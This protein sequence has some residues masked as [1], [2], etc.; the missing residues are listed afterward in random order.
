[1]TSSFYS[2]KFVVR[3]SKCLRLPVVRFCVGEGLSWFGVPCCCGVFKGFER[4]ACHV[5]IFTDGRFTRLP[6]KGRVWNWIYFVPQE[7]YAPDPL[8]LYVAI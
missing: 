7:N 5:G 4:R 8:N 1:M 3:A 2:T 6:E